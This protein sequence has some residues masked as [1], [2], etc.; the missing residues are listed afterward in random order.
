MTVAAER[1]QEMEIRMEHMQQEV[2]EARQALARNYMQQQEQKGQAEKAQQLLQKELDDARRELAIRTE[3]LR[4]LENTA[5]ALEGKLRDTEET[6][7][8]TSVVLRATQQSEQALTSEASALLQALKD[9]IDDGDKLH[10]MVQA[11]RDDEINRRFLTREFN[12]SI[13][14]IVK[15][16]RSKLEDIAASNKEHQRIVGEVVSSDHAQRLVAIEEARVVVSEMTE[17]MARACDHVSFGTSHETVP[18]LES[19]KDNIKLNIDE[20]RSMILSGDKD[21]SRSCAAAEQQLTNFSKALLEMN[22]KHDSK[23][24]DSLFDVETAISNSKTKAEMMVK[25]A[26]EAIEAAQARSLGARL[27][28]KNMFNNWKE[29]GNEAA[30]RINDLSYTQHL[31]LENTH[32]LLKSE[33]ER[34]EAVNEALKAQLES[35]NC[36]DASQREA[37]ELQTRQLMLQQKQIDEAKQC[38]EL[39][40]GSVV[41]TVVNEVKNLVTM[42]MKLIMADQSQR[43]EEL[44]ST[45]ASI[46]EL[47]G[48]LCNASVQMFDELRSTN[49]SLAAEGR[50]LQSTDASLLTVL[51]D[52]KTAMTSIQREAEG[53]QN[54]LS[55]YEIETEEQLRELE[56]V[57]N[58]I[59]N[60]RQGMLTAGKACAKHMEKSID[61]ATES[62]SEIA[63]IGSEA[64]SFS[65]NVVIREAA[66]SLAHIEEPRPNLLLNVSNHL[67]SMENSVVGGAKQ[68]SVLAQMHSDEI[69]ETT[70]SISNTAANFKESTCA[71]HRSQCNLS[72]DKLAAVVQ[73][74]VDATEVL[75]SDCG[76]IIGSAAEKTQAFGGSVIAMDDQVDTAPPRKT[77]EFTEKLTATPREEVLLEGFRREQD[78][79]TSI[80]SSSEDTSGDVNISETSGVLR[81]IFSS[82]HTS[83]GAASPGKRR[84]IESSQSARRAKQKVK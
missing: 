84:R 2:E 22:A 52:G 61:I 3:D 36:R 50:K 5:K 27:M 55:L 74:H 54:S 75:V 21:L 62:I 7:R 45:I 49:A 48:V 80:V 38:Q 12:R 70:A 64:I 13:A 15:V 33:M 23:V 20:M 57:N 66:I 10:K 35:L 17:M 53:Q 44:K 72:R 59:E 34:H 69:F 31:V 16:A 58:E 60:A 29:T 25:D 73:S 40:C 39:L 9:S 82:N 11:S 47:N 68:L 56:A 30:H 28:L 65:Q 14:D 41:D 6:L 78:D 26:E 51:D 37:L 4:L 81:E 63:V 67:D 18:L 76:G 46:K 8:K 79:P 71:Q 77:I 1:W 42:Q 83:E 19:L 24:K 43:T 32:D